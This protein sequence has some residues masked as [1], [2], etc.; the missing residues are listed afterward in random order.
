M[1][2]RYLFY[3]FSSY[4]LFLSLTVK[5]KGNVKR[6]TCKLYH[7]KIY[8]CGTFLIVYKTLNLLIVVRFDVSEGEFHNSEFGEVI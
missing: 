4:Y 2:V 6:V 5:L 7:H 1:I 8:L 3:R